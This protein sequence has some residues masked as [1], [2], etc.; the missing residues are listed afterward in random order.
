MKRVGRVGVG[1]G[2]LAVTVGD[3]DT[4]CMPEGETGQTPSA[5]AHLD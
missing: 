3:G 4:L 5:V 2:H 1:T